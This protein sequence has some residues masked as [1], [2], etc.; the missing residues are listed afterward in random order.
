MITLSERFLEMGE[1]N[2][3]ALELQRIIKGTY[4]IDKKEHEN[5]T[6]VGKVIGINI[7]PKD[8]KTRLEVKHENGISSWWEVNYDEYELN[9]LERYLFNEIPLY[10]NGEFIEEMEI[11]VRPFYK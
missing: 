11:L 9:E 5:D 10:K 2:R 1:T 3:T 4:E 7:E 6:F 8:G